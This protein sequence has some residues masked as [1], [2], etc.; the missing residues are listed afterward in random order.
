MLLLAKLAL[1]KILS[2]NIFG[3]KATIFCVYHY[4][5]SVIDVNL[6]IVLFKLASL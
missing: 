4:M 6:N 5:E 2:V 3:F 1:E